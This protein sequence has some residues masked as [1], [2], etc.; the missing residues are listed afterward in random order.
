MEFSHV[1]ELFCDDS[2][3]KMRAERLYLDT[4][5]G[6]LYSKWQI[7]ERMKP[8]PVLYDEEG[9]LIDNKPNYEDPEGE[10]YIKPLYEDKM[11]KRAED[12]EQFINDELQHYNANER[13]ALDD[14]LVRLYN[15]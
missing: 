13:A 14:M 7:K 2:E 12:S 6:Q 5:D 15:H 8:P 1:I 3:I 4:D 10:N 9:E 11:A